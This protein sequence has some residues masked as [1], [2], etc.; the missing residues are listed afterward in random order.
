MRP[1]V[2]DAAPEIDPPHTRPHVGARKGL[3]GRDGDP[4]MRHQ[5]HS[6][7]AR[8][9]LDRPRLLAW[10]PEATGAW[11]T[12]LSAPAG[13]G[14][15]TCVAAMAARMA[16]DGQSLLFAATDDERRPAI[17]PL[18]LGVSATTSAY[19]QVVSLDLALDI[20]RESTAP[21]T[22]IVDDLDRTPDAGAFVQHLAS[23]RAKSV[24][25]LATARERMSGG[26]A[27]LQVNG[28]LRELGVAQLRFTDEETSE[29]FAAA[30]V[31]L[32]PVVRA[33]VHRITEGWPAALQM[34]CHLLSQNLRTRADLIQRLARP[35]GPLGRYLSEEMLGRAP[36][37]TRSYVLEAGALGRFT[38]EMLED[39][40]GCTNGD[41]M[42]RRLD[43]AGFF[44]AS[45]DADDR[46]RTFHPLVSAFLEATLRREAPTRSRL[47]HNRAA[48]WHDARG[49]LSEAIS[50]AFAAQD[51]SEAT[52]LLDRASAARERI[53][54][55]R[56]F[57]SWASRLNT[58]TLDTYPSIRIEAACAHAVLFEFDASRAHLDA[59]RASSGAISSKTSDELLATDAILAAFADEPA[60]ALAACERGLK[61]VQ[62]S[63]AYVLGCLHLA[64]GV[65]WIGRGEFDRA[66][67]ALLEAR[68][69]YEN[70]HSR[71]GA[72]M[73]LAMTGLVAAVE[74][75]IGRAL[76]TWSEGEALV[77]PMDTAPTIE[78]VAIGYM[79][80]ALYEQNKLEDVDAYIARCFS[81]T[82]EVLMPDMVAALYVAAV[83]T[84]FARGQHAA[85]ERYLEE[86]EVAGT[87]RRWSRLVQ[88]AGWERVNLA[89]WREDWAEAR[90]A[91][92]AIEAKS[93][94]LP[95]A[96]RALDV[97]GE[98]LGAMRFE[99]HLNPSRTLLAELRGAIAKSLNQ[100]QIWR[101]SRLMVLDGVARE[102]LGDRPG[103]LRAMSRAIS[104]GAT[105][106]LVRTFVD[107][108]AK[109][110]ALVRTLAEQEARTPS[111]V[112]V[113][114][115]DILAAV[116]AEPYRM[117][118]RLGQVERLS[119][120]EVDV[121]QMVAAGLSNRELAD[122]L[123]VTEN[124]VKWHLQH[125]FAKLGVQNRTRA[126]IVGREHSLIE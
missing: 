110:T 106:G 32:D 44:L 117:E 7:D 56:A 82:A 28:N 68:A 96:P 25:L 5:G 23:C 80:L 16:A 2:S 83:R 79:P 90:R 77:R 19:A 57:T 43:D 87:R 39:A 126:I 54:R 15:T 45:D 36:P 78:S 107:E 10:I 41:L 52:R 118:Q 75:Q 81:S 98:G 1:T 125:V 37:D 30:Q 8:P 122:R 40:I 31:V 73:A 105:G 74:G 91:R 64:G 108:G 22:V 60:A 53:G 46:W 121:L 21:L 17:E 33:D 27:R 109:A 72:A 99:A 65:G 13:Y 111:R 55:W 3:D 61:E 112:P 86:A 104:T 92:R 88:V 4:N 42:I 70:G 101:A 14:K 123:S 58:E 20:A 97:E 89:L 35:S 24:T 114:F 84:A 67:A 102:G 49:Q 66:R 124:T 50:H 62:G 113:D 71:F 94:G 69:V 115:N 116:G 93:H 38:A 103:A 119:R 51:I 59:V 9:L 120:R 11:A 48:A 63:D 100:N 47:L 95:S 34:S 85:A 29:F 26:F 18:A 6:A 12:V 76:A